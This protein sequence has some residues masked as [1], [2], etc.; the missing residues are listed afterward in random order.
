M[1]RPEKLLWLSDSRGMYIPR[2]FTIINRHLVTGVCDEDWKILEAGPD[3]EGYWDAWIEV[4][5]QAR[6]SM[7]GVD[8][9]L[10][11]DGDLWLIPIGM[12]WDEEADDW[13]WPYTKEQP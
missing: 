9:H 3:S 2:D 5:D 4:C 6:V 8:Y 12:T 10:E 11:H 1:S 13:R 7:N